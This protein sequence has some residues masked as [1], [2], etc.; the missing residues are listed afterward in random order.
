MK[1]VALLVYQMFLSQ[2][3]TSTQ[4]TIIMP[5]TTVA[6]LK[7]KIVPVIIILFYD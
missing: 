4:P 3:A 6:P 7:P 1:Y 2:S 5:S